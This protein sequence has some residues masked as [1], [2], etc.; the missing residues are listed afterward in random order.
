MHTLGELYP[1]QASLC[2]QLMIYALH[3]TATFALHEQLPAEVEILKPQLPMKPSIQHD[4]STDFSEFLL[5]VREKLLNMATIQSEKMQEDLKSGVPGGEGAGAVPLKSPAGVQP[6]M[7]STHAHAPVVS[8]KEP[9]GTKEGEEGARED[10]GQDTDPG[11]R[12]CFP[13]R[14]SP[15]HRAV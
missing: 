4:N 14:Y 3:N 1:P 5:Q 8:L 9:S 7:V 11:G 13:L 2:R 12:R 15:R 6:E 10:V